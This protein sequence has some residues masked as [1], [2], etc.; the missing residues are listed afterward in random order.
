MTNEETIYMG[1][2]LEGNTDKESAFKGVMSKAWKPVTIGSL[3]GIVIGTG[4]IL[5]THIDME[6]GA[7]S[8][9][10]PANDK[11]NVQETP[12]AEQAVEPE[13]SAPALKIASVDDA[14]SFD[15]AFVSAREQVGAGGVFYWRGVIFSTYTADEWETMTEDQH[16]SFAQQ[17]RPEVEAK[18]IT[19]EEI[20]SQIAQYEEAEPDVDDIV[21]DELLAAEDVNEVVV[22]D[23]VEVAPD[24]AFEENPEQE[25]NVDIAIDDSALDKINEDIAVA[26]APMYETSE[27]IAIADVADEGVAIAELPEA[28][29]DVAIAETEDD[30]QDIAFAEADD[31]RLAEMFSLQPGEEVAMSEAATKG[32]NL[33]DVRAQDASFENFL[34]DDS[35]RIVGYGEFDGHVVRGLDLDGDDV[36]DI[37]VIDVDDSGDLSREDIIMEEGNG[38]QSTYGE[39]QDFA[40][41][42]M[43]D[44]NHPM[45]PNPDVAD[46]MPDYMDD[47]LAQ[48]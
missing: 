2:G 9:N 24:M 34:S 27:D 31:I 46:D 32:A 41:H 44:D 1:N 10:L 47:A 11:P 8:D 4:A 16:E 21:Q 25:E 30:V 6:S 45:T 12:V 39:L 26:A 5:A 37:A 36:V 28:D 38:N 48:L 42:Q 22:A 15:E 29:P 18:D 43:N 20:Q 17:V 14:L 19:A 23:D 7:E 35:V 3:T 33:D 40:M 13:E